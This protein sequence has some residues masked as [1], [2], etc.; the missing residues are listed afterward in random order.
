MS[1]SPSGRAS[2]PEGTASSAL[3]PFGGGED[4]IAPTASIPAPPHRRRFLLHHRGVKWSARHRAGLG[5]CRPPCPSY[6][7]QWLSPVIDWSGAAIR[8]FCWT[9]LGLLSAA[10][11]AA[12]A[13]RFKG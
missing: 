3:I 8:G 4:A 12:S 6:A 7:I 13:G 5:R 2:G 9:L 11:A 10:A 1:P